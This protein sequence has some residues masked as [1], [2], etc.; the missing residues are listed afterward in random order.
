MKEFA[1]PHC[2]VGPPALVGRIKT[3][4]NGPEDLLV[5]SLGAS[6]VLII[7]HAFGIIE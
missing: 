3:P 2:T 5:D 6:N 4:E 7:H 1:P